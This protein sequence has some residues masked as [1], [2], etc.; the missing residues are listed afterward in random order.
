MVLRNRALVVAGGVAV[1][2]LASVALAPAQQSDIPNNPFAH[3]PAAVAA[4]QKLFNSTCAVCHGQGATGGRGPAL[5]TGNFTHGSGDYD[6]FQVI[7]G[8]VAGTEMPNFSALPSDD[9]W[10]LVTYI[11]S[12]SS[13]AAATGTV[14]AG[15]PAA[16]QALFFGA[17]NCTSCHEIN[18]RGSD[19]AP[20][21]SAV[22]QHPLAAIRADIAHPVRGFRG[23]R[24]AAQIVTVTTKDGHNYSGLSRAED[25]FTL[26]LELANGGFAL[27]KKSDIASQTSAGPL[28]PQVA[29]TSKQMDDIAA[30]LATQKQRDFTQTSKIN[31]APVL[32]YDRIVK[33]EPKNWATYW[34][35]YKGF[36]FSALNQI[37]RQQ[38]PQPCRALEH[39]ATGRIHL[40]SH[41]HRGRRHHVYFRLAGRSLC[42]GCQDRHGAVEFQA[43]AGH[44]EPLPDQSVQSWRRGF[45]RP[46]ILRHT[47]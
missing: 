46:G 27:L 18:G 26:D 42:P 15:D 7:H 5:N 47:G 6:I 35:D 43:Q 21:L 45:G 20:D 16:G 23:F 1:L 8:G 24:P 17:G 31:P 40:G 9:V 10:R 37:N 3:D 41:A 36:H 44:Q 33:P 22:G 14:A 4:G 32:P 29:L 13:A 28:K 30:F 34:G 38:C 39:A 12:L 11:K 19:Y 25:S 2:V